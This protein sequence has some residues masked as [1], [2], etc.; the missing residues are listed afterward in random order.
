MIHPN[1][2]PATTWIGISL[3]I[4]VLSLF[5]FVLIPDD[6]PK[7]KKEIKKDTTKIDIEQMQQKN[8]I[9][10]SRSLMLDSL[11]MQIDSLKKAK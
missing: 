10:K 5:A 6:P 2:K 7:P 8:E 3:I 9:T 1:F 11:I 4:V